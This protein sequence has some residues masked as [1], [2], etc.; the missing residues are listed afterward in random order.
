MVEHGIYELPVNFKR[1]HISLAHSN[2]DIDQAL[3]V[4]DVVMGEMQRVV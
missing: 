2:A 3:E 4:A 1:S